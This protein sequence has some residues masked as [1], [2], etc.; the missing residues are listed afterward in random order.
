[1]SDL[2]QDGLPPLRDVIAKYDLGAKKSLGQNFLLDLN[3]TRRIA[4]AAGPLKDSTV[5]EIGPGPGGLTRALLMEGASKVVAVER[6]DRCLKA[7]ED[8][9]GAYPGRLN[10]IPAD[11]LTVTPQELIPNGPILVVANLPYNIATPL[12]INWLERPERILGGALMFQ[13][14]VA[15]RILASQ[16]NKAYGRLSIIAGWRS[17]V[18]RAFDVSPKAFVPPPKIWSTVIRFQMRKEPAFPANQT[19][20]SHVV[21]AAFNQRRKMLRQSLKSITPD[22]IALLNSAQISETERPENLSIEDFCRLA[23]AYSG[24]V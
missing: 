10:V 17:D 16:G 20:L 15:D 8:V 1:M 22:P 21:A 9:S 14:E 7:L 2:P 11:A 23:N 19:H 4:R 24:A 13:K 6:D 3:L 12:F 18:K 5:F